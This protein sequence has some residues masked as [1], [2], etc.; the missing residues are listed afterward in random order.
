[1][2]PVLHAFHA[3]TLAPEGGW[4]SVYEIA[5][6]LMREGATLQKAKADLGTMLQVRSG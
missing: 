6:N 5:V 2:R 4:E 1:V 3:Q